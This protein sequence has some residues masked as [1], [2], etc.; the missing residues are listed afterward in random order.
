MHDIHTHIGQ[1][2]NTYYDF[3]DVFMALKNNGIIETTFSYL[4]PLFTDYDS[5]ID[6]YKAMTE[7]SKEAV[8]F[9]KQIGLKTNQLYWVDPI[10]LLGGLSLDSVIKEG[11]Y[12]GLVIHPLLNDWNPNKE[13]N[14]SLLTEVFKFAEKNKY[15]IYFH[16]GCSEKDNPLQFEKWF[17]VFSRVRVHL[18]HCKDSE[19][20]IKLFS[21]YENLVGDTAFC[22]EDSYK[23][24]C[25]AGFKNRMFFGTDFPINHW[26]EHHGEEYFPV[27]EKSLTENYAKT[28]KLYNGLLFS[29]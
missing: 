6:F 10:L 14:A 25:N 17:S 23:A 12:K 22:P 26:Y 20:I 27:N 28:L 19:P 18:A 29:N 21:K 2:Y 3:H 9:A 24:I 7:E 8:T 16:T 15:E 5:A 1:F 4:T 13:T 11:D